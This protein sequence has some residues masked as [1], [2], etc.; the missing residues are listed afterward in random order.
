VTGG[1]TSA[2]I[3]SRAAERNAAKPQ[4]DQSG[5]VRINWLG[6]WVEATSGIEPEYTVLQTVA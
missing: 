6:W 2:V 5:G 1:E 3:R 4:C